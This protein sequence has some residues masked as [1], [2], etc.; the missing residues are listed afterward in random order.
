MRRP[1]NFVQ[2]TKS[3]VLVSQKSESFPVR[4]ASATRGTV[5]ALSKRSKK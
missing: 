1:E 2:K 5:S 4:I 3:C